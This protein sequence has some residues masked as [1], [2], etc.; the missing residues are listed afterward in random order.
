MT[1]PLPRPALFALLGLLLVTSAL[2]ATKAMNHGGSRAG[3]LAAPSHP[4]S[5]HK[6]A[7]RA[8]A[9]APAARP[10]P[11]HRQA[12]AVHPAPAPKPA[13]KAQSSSAASEDAPPAVA[14]ALARHELTV[15]L[16]S[17]DS[18]DDTATRASVEALHSRGGRIAI[19]SDGLANLS[20]YGGIVSG[21]AI[22]R[23]PAVVIVGPDHAAHL[24]QGYVDPA[25][26]LQ[27]VE[28]AR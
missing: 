8:H 1:L 11:A 7:P 24:L 2:V 18:A 17:G 12:P 3:S 5:P 22:S 15:L 26:L 6:A 19:F 14:Q 16:F 4:A 28:D 27:A 23:A 10:K 21:L 9:P 20:H 13:A 25:T